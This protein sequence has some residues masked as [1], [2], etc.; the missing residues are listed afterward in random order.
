MTCVFWLRTTE[1]SLIT[2]VLTCLAATALPMIIWT[3]LVERVHRTSQTGLNF[4]RPLRPLEDC[5]DT[6]RTKL[7]GLLGT[8]LCIF[9]VYFVVPTY[10]E[11][12][13]ALYLATL[14]FV[15]LPLIAVSIPYIFLVDRHQIEPRDGLWHT[16]RW[17]LGDRRNADTEAVK[18]HARCWLI[19]AF[20]LAFMV[21]IVPGVIASVTGPTTEEI[22]SSQ[23]AVFLWTIQFIFLFDVCFGTIGYILTLRPLGSHIRSANPHLS[24]WVAALICYP[25]FIL[26]HADGPLNY[27]ADTQPWHTWFEGDPI[28]LGLWGGILVILAGIYASATIIFGIRFSNLTNRGIITNGPYRLAKHPAY[29]SKN[30]YWWLVHLPFLTTGEFGDGLRNCLLLLCVNLIYLWRAKTEET[31]LRADPA[32]RAYSRWLAEHSPAAHIRLKL[33]RGRMSIG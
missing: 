19:K 22:F 29:L 32:Y 5:L 15:A 10:S 14:K 28:L 17:L 21:S 3:L 20:F 18:E 23:S 1:L 33:K 31:H 7:I 2:Q 26:M 4:S 27:R 11:P 30:L 6:T 8:W 9:G 25:P 24:A 12:Q 13:F 16:G